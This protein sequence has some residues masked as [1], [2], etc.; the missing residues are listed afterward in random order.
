MILEGFNYTVLSYFIGGI[1]TNGESMHVTLSNKQL[2]SNKKRIGY[3][4]V[5]H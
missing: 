2:G 5:T 1:P 3:V 4:Y